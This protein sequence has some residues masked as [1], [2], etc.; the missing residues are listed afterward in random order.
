MK[1][2][3]FQNGMSRQSCKAKLIIKS[4]EPNPT[5][6]HTCKK[7]EKTKINDD[8]NEINEYLVIASKDLPKY[9]NQ[10]YQALICSLNEKYKAIKIQSSL[11]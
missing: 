2:L 7:Y 10:I 8:E 9:P 6:I 11:Q 1:S 4:G 3:I 5:E